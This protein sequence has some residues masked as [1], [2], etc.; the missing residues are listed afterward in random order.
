MSLIYDV[1]L[2]YKTG[3]TQ[4][5]N[6]LP[7]TLRAALMFEK[8]PPMVGAEADVPDKRY[9]LPPNIVRYL[10]PVSETSG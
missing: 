9:S 2:A 1:E 5:R 4:P 10:V 8:N 3:L 7:A 6:P